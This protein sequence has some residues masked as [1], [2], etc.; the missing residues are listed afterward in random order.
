MSLPNMLRTT[1]QRGTRSLA[2][3]AS[4]ASNG[5]SLVGVSA[6]NSSSSRP[7]LFST[8]SSS[9]SSIFCQ[10]SQKRTLAS[11]STRYT[12]TAKFTASPLTDGQYHSLANSLLDSLQES[13]E[14]LL[15]EADVDR[16]EQD[17]APSERV[18]GASEWDIEC[19][20]GV[21]NLRCGVHGTYV[22]NKQPPNKQIWLS[23]PKSGPKRFDYDA[24][25]NTWFCLK[26]GETST[27][28]HILDHELS[29]VFD[30]TV[31]LDFNAD[32]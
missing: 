1:T 8:S 17:A 28:K 19:A 18:S 2:I 25:T 11:T 13:F 5:R 24:D 22:I 16:L 31:D 12:P 3:V 21:L 23:S 20:S 27:L 7:T 4:S 32:F 9:S 30:T 10:S 6:R 26:D 29:G 15:E 14:S